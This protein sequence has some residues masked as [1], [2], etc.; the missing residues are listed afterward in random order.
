MSGSMVDN[1]KKF[2]ETEEGKKSIE[3]FRRSIEI[4]EER[5]KK[6][7]NFVESLSDEKFEI[8]FAKLLEWENKKEDYYYDVKHVI[9][10]T[11]VFSYTIDAF[12]KLGKPYKSKDTFFSGG[13]KY[14][15]Y[16]VKIYCGQGCF[17]RIM[18]GKKIIFQST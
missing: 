8:L 13:C 17:T 3:R 14:R 6:V 15:G 11:K 9:T 18:K 1:L 2:L 10:Q 12:F 16:T 7:C 5:K 4:E